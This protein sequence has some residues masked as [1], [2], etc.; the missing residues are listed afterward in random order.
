MSERAIFKCGTSAVPA[1]VQEFDVSG[2][3]LPFVPSSVSVSLRQPS[4]SALIVGAFVAGEAT[5]DGFRVVLTAP[6]ETEGY[7]LDWQ[8]FAGALLLGDADTLA[9]SY[10]ELMKSVADFLGRPL[11]AM[12]D[13]E[14][15]KV[16][17]FVQSGVRNFY[18]P[19]KMEGVDETFEWSFL[20]QKGGAALTPGVSS[21]ILPDGFGRI[22]GQITWADRV[23]TSIPVIPYGELMKFSA[24]GEKG[25]PRLASVISRRDFGSKGQRKEILFWPTPEVSGEV[26]F[27][28]DADDGRIGEERPYPLGGAMYSE[29]ILESCLAVAEQRANDEEGLHTSNFNRLLISSIERDRK[30]GAQSFGM[31]GDSANSLNW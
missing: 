24:S 19:P 3:A 5:P 17:S 6:L 10:D 18:Y 4:A 16:D 1:G 2:L 22:L 27:V 23:R 26:S 29:L 21:Y 7:M 25:V 15:E 13:D 14:K 8:A 31:I 9:I 20:R 30:S 28:C 12:T 11:S